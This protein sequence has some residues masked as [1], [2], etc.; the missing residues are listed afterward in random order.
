MSMYRCAIA[1]CLPAGQPTGNLDTAM[2]H[3]VL[4]LLEQ[5]HADGTTIVM[6]THDP[7]LANGAERNIH[8]IDGRL[9]APRP[10]HRL[11]RPAASSPQVEP[12]S[13]C[14]KSQRGVSSI[15]VH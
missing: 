13:N 3:Q 12:E 9:A 2:A 4:D 11:S 14:C 7:V 8:L 5:I 15:L 10:Y 1:D 6:V